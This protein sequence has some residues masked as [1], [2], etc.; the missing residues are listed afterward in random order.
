MANL[1]STPAWERVVG[2]IGLVLILV[3]IGFLLWSAINKTDNPAAI[4]VEIRDTT[5]VPTGYL[6][7]VTVRNS[8]DETT[9]NLQLE[10]HLNFA[11]RESEVS[12]VTVDYLA[13]GSSKELGFYFTQD[14]SSGDLVFRPLGFQVP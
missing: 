12:T 2:F 9:E 6:V 14:P 1:S 7:R 10:A 11:A 4:D 3:T 13:P 8:G 5:S